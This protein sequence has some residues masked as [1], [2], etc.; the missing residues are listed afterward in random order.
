MTSFVIKFRKSLLVSGIALLSI[1]PFAIRAWWDLYHR[2]SKWQLVDLD[3]LS[4]TE[5]RQVVVALG[6]PRSDDGGR[7]RFRKEEL[8]DA[9][10]NRAM[11]F[12]VDECR[13]KE[14]EV[15]DQGR[16]L[17][18]LRNEWTTTP[19]AQWRSM[20]DALEGQWEPPSGE[21]PPWRVSLEWKQVSP[22]LNEFTL[23][24]QCDELGLRSIY[25]AGAD[26]ES[27]VPVE[28]AQCNLRSDAFEQL[29]A[30]L[31][32]LGWSGFA[33]L[34]AIV[35]FIAMRPTPGKRSP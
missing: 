34:G 11:G 15:V 14:S 26:L 20:V 29:T 30:I 18:T 3:R 8:G 16:T 23:T 24:M 2:P 7:A 27:V 28:Y 35:A 19:P 13:A 12:S 9:R 22:A 10:I 25:G 21:N 1:S 31:G 6:F 17:I 33:V 5:R 4:E 32:S